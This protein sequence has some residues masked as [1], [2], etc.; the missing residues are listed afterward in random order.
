[1][2][3]GKEFNELKNILGPSKIKKRSPEK[4]LERER[5]FRQHFFKINLFGGG[6]DGGGIG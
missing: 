6:K 5:S 1:M 4:N 3:R 2:K